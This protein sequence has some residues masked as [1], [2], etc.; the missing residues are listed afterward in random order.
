MGSP[1]ELSVK[2]LLM[3]CLLQVPS[4]G[5]WGHNGK[6]CVS[7]VTSECSGLDVHAALEA[8]LTPLITML[9]LWALTAAFGHCPGRDGFWGNEA[10]PLEWLSL[11]WKGFLDWLG[12][13][14]TPMTKSLSWIIIWHYVILTQ[15][16]VSGLMFN[17]PGFFCAVFGFFFFGSLECSAVLLLLQILPDSPAVFT[18]SSA[19]T[20]CPK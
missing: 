9:H 18:E 5:K 1:E 7:P 12:C 2:G 16:S 20:D 8:L 15:T 14:W 4:A 3:S 11:D 13:P 6:E 19:G 17:V 10:R